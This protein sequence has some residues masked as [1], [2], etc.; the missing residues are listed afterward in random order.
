LGL[1][2]WDNL[3]LALFGLLALVAFAA[4]RSRALD[5]L[6]AGDETAQSLGIAPKRLRSQVFGVAALATACFVAL[7]GVIGFVGLMV[8]H[9]ARSLCGAL[10]GRLLVVSALAGAVLMLGS[11]LLCRTLLPPQELPIG[12]VTAALGGMFVVFLV[13]RTSS[14]STPS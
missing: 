8:P 10:H 4:T 12:I 11:D 6:L 2:R 7:T 3:G 5:A 14:L 1:A 9:L 13:L